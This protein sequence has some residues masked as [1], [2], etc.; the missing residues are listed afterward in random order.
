MSDLNTPVFDKLAR[1]LD[2]TDKEKL[3][4]LARYAPGWSK[5]AIAYLL[6]A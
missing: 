1:Q 4:Q 2:D 3:K 5:P 6:A